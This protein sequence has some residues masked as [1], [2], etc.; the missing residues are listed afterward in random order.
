MVF[1]FNLM[2][3]LW[4]KECKIFDQQRKASEIG[5][6]TTKDKIRGK[7]PGTVQWREGLDLGQV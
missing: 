2:L 7:I 1:F 5:S 4:R 3:I 6:V